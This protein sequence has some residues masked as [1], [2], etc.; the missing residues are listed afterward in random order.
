MPRTLRTTLLAVLATL[1]LPAC[2][3]DFGKG[4]DR[5]YSNIP[6][7]HEDETEGEAF[8]R[9]MD[10]KYQAGGDAEASLQN[11]GGQRP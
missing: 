4:F 10:Q 11:D 7:G 8:A 2:Q 9:E 3:V 5:F 6:G 1:L